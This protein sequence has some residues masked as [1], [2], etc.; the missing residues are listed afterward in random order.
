[1]PT[2][3]GESV[4][5]SAGLDVVGAVEPRIAEAIAGE[6]AAQRGSLKLIASENYASPATLLAMGNWL[7]DKYAEGTIGRR[8]YAGCQQVDTVEAIAAEHTRAVFG[9]PARLLAAALR[10]RRQPSRVLGHPRPPGR[11]PGVAPRAGP[12]RQRP[13]RKRLGRAAPRAG[14]PA[15]A[16]HGIG[17]RWP[18]HPRVPAQHLRQNVPA[19][20]L[21]H[22]PGHRP[23]RLRRPAP[24]RAGVPPTHPHRRVLLLPPADQLRAHARNRRRGRPPCSWTWRTS[25][26]WSPGKSSPATSTLCRTPTSSPPPPTRRCEAPGV[27]WSCATTNSPNTSTAGRAVS[28]RQS[29]RTTGA[30]THRRRSG[31]RGRRPGGR[32]APRLQPESEP[33]SVS[34]YG[35]TGAAASHS[36]S[37]CRTAI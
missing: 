1:M 4:A 2:P 7:S 26:G 28:L 27:A 14:R 29:V 34:G 5:F 33:G 19:T 31:P 25:P 35:Q 16:P 37:T 11:D 32:R 12:P 10:H 21:R 15:D 36:A 20:Q 17:R 6:L 3:A 9:G 8:F 13:Q 23:T 30:R 18:P 22:R 24:H